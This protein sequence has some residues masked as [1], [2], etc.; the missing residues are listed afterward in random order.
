MKNLLKSLLILAA[1]IALNASAEMNLVGY[2]IPTLTQVDGQ[3]AYDKIINQ[4]KSVSGKNWNYT[5]M[6]PARA[7]NAF[8]SGSADCIGPL[9]KDFYTGGDVIQ[10]D[11][12]NIAKIYIYTAEGSTALTSAEQLKGKNVGA[13][14]GMPYG[15]DF[16]SAGLKVSYVSSIDKNLKKLKAG[17]LDAFVAYVP[18]AWFVPGVQALSHDENKPLAVHEDAFTCKNTTAAQAFVKEFNAALAE[19]KSSGKVREILG[20]TYITE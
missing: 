19:L 18:D 12:F 20:D 7:D 17:R 4:V 6:P 9:D 10:T 3:G 13:R 2:D 1:P 16:D 5:V 15:P 14:K 11:Y 8:S